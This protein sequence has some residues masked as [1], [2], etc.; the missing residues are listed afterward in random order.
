MPQAIEQEGRAGMTV[1]EPFQILHER[2][3]DCSDA[4]DV[5]STD[6]YMAAKREEQKCH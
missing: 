6:D 3:L 2:G 4:A 1:S 5:Q